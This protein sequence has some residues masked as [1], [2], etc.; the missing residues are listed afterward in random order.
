ME[1]IM[2][3]PVVTEINVDLDGVLVNFLKTAVEVSGINPEQDSKD[4][5]N[6]VLR[7]D[8]WKAIES[9]VKSGGKFFEVMEP[10]E[11]A[12]VLW[13]YLQG[14]D[15]PKVINSATGHVIGAS[16][17]KRNWVRRHLGHE[18]ANSARFVR[19]AVHKSQYAGPSKILIDDRRKAIDPWVAAGGIGI[20]HVNAHLTIAQLKEMG[21]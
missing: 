4:G 20:L 8:F 12:F 11:D 10:M 3:Y 21:L 1:H 9:H 19:D 2:T 18:I 15:V 6:K 13:E 5:T 7:R 16:G 14:L 17:E